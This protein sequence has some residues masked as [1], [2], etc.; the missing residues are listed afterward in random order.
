MA[1][2][3]YSK[4]ERELHEAL[5]RMR[6]KNLEEGKTVLSKRAAEYYGLE[7]KEPRPIPEESVAKLLREEA[8]REEAEE[9][10]QKE[11]EKLKPIKEKIEE[12]KVAFPPPPSVE[13]EEEIENPLEIVRELPVYDVM[14]KAKPQSVRPPKAAL[15]PLPEVP[16]SDKFFEPTS[17]LYILRQ[18][19]LWL[20]R[21]HY[22]NRYELLGTTREEVMGFRKT[23]RLSEAQLSRIKELNA[24]ADEVKADIMAKEGMHTDEKQI[25]TQKQKHRTKRFNV[26]DTW[27]PL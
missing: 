11:V 2:I 16:P 15:P 25:E 19:I 27:L 17:H 3:D 6:I 14:K 12:G 23:K 9:Q 21:K 18:H 24:R 22:D 8:A 7:E 20:K 10:K 5:Q 4:A 1:K 13:E 26:R